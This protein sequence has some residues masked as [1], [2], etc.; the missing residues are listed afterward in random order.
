VNEPA[1][2]FVKKKLLYQ[3]R[4]TET[5]SRRIKKEENKAVKN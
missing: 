1:P 5:N 2:S 4:K 3:Y